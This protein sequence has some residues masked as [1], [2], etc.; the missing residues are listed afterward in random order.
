M[1]GNAHNEAEG[2]D[3]LERERSAIETAHFVDGHAEFPE[4][5]QWL[6]VRQPLVAL[7]HLLGLAFQV[8]QD[9]YL[10]LQFPRRVVP[11]LDHAIVIRAQTDNHRDGQLLQRPHGVDDISIRG[12]PVR[13]DD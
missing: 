8:V 12:F 5:M 7:V 3:L 2:A 6:C 13:A 1:K 9:L 4:A 11:V 10:D